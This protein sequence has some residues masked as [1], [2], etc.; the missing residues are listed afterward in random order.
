MIFSVDFLVSV[1]RVLLITFGQYTKYI[2]E[3]KEEWSKIAQFVW[4]EYLEFLILVYPN[5]KFDRRRF[6]GDTEIHKLCNDCLCAFVFDLQPY[7]LRLED[8]LIKSYLQETNDFEGEW[9]RVYPPFVVQLLF[10]IRK[11]KPKPVSP[12]A[13]WK[14]KYNMKDYQGLLDH[15]EDDKEFPKLRL[16]LR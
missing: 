10:K 16:A 5:P 4:Y 9:S 6:F 3:K 12:K 15:W 11:E 2:N 1:E 8:L 7:Y 13:I 14:G